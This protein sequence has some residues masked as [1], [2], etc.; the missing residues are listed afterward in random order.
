MARIGRFAS[1]FGRTRVDGG[2]CFFA[3]S[4][5]T[6]HSLVDENV[7]TARVATSHG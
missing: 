1:T 3:G 6:L 7:I 4:S 2:D 5:S